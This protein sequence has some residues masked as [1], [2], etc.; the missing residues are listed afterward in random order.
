MVGG[1]QYIRMTTQL[2][3]FAVVATGREMVGSAGAKSPDASLPG[4]GAVKVHAGKTGIVGLATPEL[5]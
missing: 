2:R 1:H 3:A 4:Y 5:R